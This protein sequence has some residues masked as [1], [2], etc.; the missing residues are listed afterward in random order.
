MA[1]GGVHGLYVYR[2]AEPGATELSQDSPEYVLVYDIIDIALGV[3]ESEQGRTV[4]Y[5]LALAIIQGVRN[6][7]RRCL[8]P[9][10]DRDFRD[11]PQY[12]SMFLQKMRAGFPE[13][14]IVPNKVEAT[15][16]RDDW[17]SGESTLRDFVPYDAGR[18]VL[19]SMIIDDMLA[20]TNENAHNV[21][22]FDMVV[23][24]SHELCH[25][26]TGFLTGTATPQT[27]DVVA[28]EGQSREAG[29]FFEFHAFGGI[30]DFFASESDPRNAHQPGVAYLFENVKNTARGKR[31][32]LEYIRQFIASRG[33]IGL[34]IGLSNS[35]SWTTRNDL[36]RR[37][38]QMNVL[39][40]QEFTAMQQQ[41]RL[42]SGSAA[43][44]SATRHR[45]L[46]PN[47]DQY[48]YEY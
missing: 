41:G 4:L 36:K 28:I 30:A 23:S 44:S 43:S 37:T 2:D 17:A 18:L 26:F 16:L 34:P 8:Y 22:M 48:G 27:P 46:Q 33:A 42:G 24:V 14:Y 35:G 40:N 19:N 6:G 45:L 13:V 9:T 15:T 38:R 32:S 39:R 5:E 47:Y 7:G 29:F 31:I 3:L 25:F 12:I 1:T 21:Y 20:N 10:T 11:L